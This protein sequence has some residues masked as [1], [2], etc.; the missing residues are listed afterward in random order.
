MGQPTMRRLVALFVVLVPWLLLLPVP[1]ARGQEPAIRLTLVAQTPWNS[2]HQRRLDVIV[3]ATNGSDRAIGNLSV[4]WTLW[5]PVITRNEYVRSL[6]VDPENA[7]PI[8]GDTIPEKGTI[9]AGGSRDFRVAL[10]LSSPGISLT[11][12]L[13]YPLKIDVRTGFTSLAAIRTPVIFLVRRPLTP[14]HLTWTF[15]LHQPVAFDPHRVFTSTA[16]EKEVGPGGQLAEEITALSALTKQG[17]GTPIDVVV[18]PVLLADLTRMRAGYRVMDGGKRRVVDPGT[19]GAASAAQLLA[20]LRQIAASRR[21]ELSAWPFSAPNLP[22]MV[23]GGLARDVKVQVDLGKAMVATILGREPTDGVLSPPGS[24]VDPAS[25]SVLAAKHVELLLLEP[26]AAPPPAQPLG[27]APPPTTAIPVGRQAMVA[28]VADPSIEAMLSSPLVTEDPARGAQAVLGELAMIWLEQ[29]SNERGLAVMFP[30]AFH[31]PVGFFGPLIRG[32]G[33]AP[34]LRKTTATNLAHDFPPTRQLRLPPTTPSTFPRSYVDAIRDARRQI[35]VYRSM[36]VAPSTEPD[37]L[38]NLLLLAESGQFLSDQATGSSFVEYAR[39]ALAAVFGAV[40]PDAGQVITL[41]SSSGT[42]IPIRVTN[43]N[44]LPLRVIVRLVSPHLR[45]TPQSGMVLAA[46]STQTVD[47]D[48]RL[49]TTGRFPVRV[50]VTSPS[51]GVI[52]QDTLIVRS[53]AYNRIALIITIGA[54]ALSLLIWARRFVPRR[55]S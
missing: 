53:T 31:P 18:S 34:W 1:G 10:N 46:Q 20:D 8:A 47:F 29:P 5:G 54:A 15:V 33:A 42:G 43:G 32:L 9:K 11:D 52:N 40:R 49:A 28:V 36:L 19:G 12:S 35:E 26:S 38:A 17:P 24:S 37:R 21:V 7:V 23:E 6:S 4:G 45:G 14:L 51:G 55:T 44:S 39:G 41:T 2:I 3:R 16:M 22:A 13:V 48:V 50:E 30:G 25:L 27:F